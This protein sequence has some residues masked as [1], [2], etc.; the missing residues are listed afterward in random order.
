MAYDVKTVANE[1]LRLAR[2]GSTPLDPMKI[3]KLVY[4]AH[5]WNLALFGNSLISQDVEAWRYGP[6]IPVL[7]DEFKKFRASPI[8]A[9]AAATNEALNEQDCRFVS[10]VW[11]KYS[12][13]SAVQLSML[14]HEPG[15]AWDLTMRERGPFSTI[16]TELIRDEFLR[17]RQRK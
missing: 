12:N 8:T 15:Y 3:Q 6:V 9:D 11:Q 7:Y 13:F 2:E 10:A 14:T 4:L 16:P 1:F 17:R 5:G